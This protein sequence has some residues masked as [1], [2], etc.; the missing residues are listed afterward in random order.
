MWRADEMGLLPGMPVKPGGVLT[1]TPE[2]PGEWWAA[3]NSSLDALAGAHTTRV[4]TP[5]TVVITQTHVS[6]VIQSAF[7]GAPSATVQG[8]RPAH[9]DLNWAT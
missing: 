5:D 2:L 7:P 6:E 1:D 9:G 4:A 3:L 8:W